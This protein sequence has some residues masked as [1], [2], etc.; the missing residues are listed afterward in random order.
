MSVS[1][2]LAAGVAVLVLMGMGAAG[3]G[4]GGR[5]GPEKG[6]VDQVLDGDTIQLRSGER[7]RYLMVDAPETSGTPECYG[8][9]ARDFN[10][11]LVVEREVTLRYDQECEDRFGRLLAYVS[12]DGREVNTTLVQRGY[13]CVLH[14]PPNGDDRAEELK[15]LEDAAKAESRGLW[16]YCSPRPC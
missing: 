11:Q 1:R 4:T 13:A 3:C 9:E 7:I 16:G 10:R 12:V 5:C 8:P 6:V 2:R 14:I 15:A